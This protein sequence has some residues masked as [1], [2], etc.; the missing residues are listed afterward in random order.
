MSEDDEQKLKMSTSKPKKLPSLVQ[1][2]LR[3]FNDFDNLIIENLNGLRFIKPTPFSDPQD[4]LVEV[5]H[6]DVRGMEKSEVEKQFKDPY[7]RGYHTITILK[8]ASPFF[9]DIFLEDKTVRIFA[10]ILFESGV[11]KRRS[12][13]LSKSGA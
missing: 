8:C 2:K 9:H 4:A 6:K 7:S 3:K 11:C 5:N 12:K 1:V 10:L 13:P